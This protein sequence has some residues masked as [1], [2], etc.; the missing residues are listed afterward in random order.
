MSPNL[1]RKFIQSTFSIDLEKKEEL[2]GA[3][4]H[5][6]S[7]AEQETH[8]RSAALPHFMP[9]SILQVLTSR[10]PQGLDHLRNG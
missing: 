10:P 7:F 3:D 5:C 6:V 8:Y 9:N 4:T 2:I 1:S